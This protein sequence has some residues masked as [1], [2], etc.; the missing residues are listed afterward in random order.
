MSKYCA[1]A[2]AG[3]LYA[4][5]SCTPSEQAFVR[6]EVANHT[7]DTLTIVLHYALDSSQVRTAAVDSMR[8]Q[9]ALDTLSRVPARGVPTPDSL[10]TAAYANVRWQP[11]FTLVQHDSHWY[12]IGLQHRPNPPI[13]TPLVHYDLAKGM[14]KVKIPA[15]VTQEL[16]N[17]SQDGDGGA[18][19]AAPFEGAWLRQG[20]KTVMLGRTTEQLEQVFRPQP[21]GK[22]HLHYA[23]FLYRLTV[24]PGLV[25]EK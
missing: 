8:Q 2:L 15:G 1:L 17:I 9:L 18:Q 10:S 11:L 22:E 23:R 13:I 14:V 25:V 19:L 3:L 4:L 5:T 21:T 12:V 6:W 16:C 20:T 7:A 24:K